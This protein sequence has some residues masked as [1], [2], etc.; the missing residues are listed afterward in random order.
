MKDSMETR[1]YVGDAILA[2]GSTLKAVSLALGRSH[3]YLQQY[4]KGRT[5]ATLP[6]RERE[7]LVGQF[8]LDAARLKPP[9]VALPPPG[10]LK[11]R[12]VKPTYPDVAGGQVDPEKLRNTMD[13]PS[14]QLLMRLWAKMSPRMQ[15]A[16]MDLALAY[17][18]DARKPPDAA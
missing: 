17:A 11:D 8:G 6:E 12:R 15:Q 4:V 13:L 16:I 9:P 14:Q 7:F 2:G 1:K 5:P 18:E 3:S 10:A